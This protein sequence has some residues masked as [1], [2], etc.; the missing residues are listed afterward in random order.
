[1]LRE[2]STVKKKDLALAVAAALFPLSEIKPASPTC[3]H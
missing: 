2:I 1:M 3:S